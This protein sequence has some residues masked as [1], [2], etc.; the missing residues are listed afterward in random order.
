MAKQNVMLGKPQVQMIIRWFVEYQTEV[1][2]ANDKEW[3]L[4]RYLHEV[5][6]I[7][8]PEWMVSDMKY[9]LETRND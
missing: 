6:E 9:D 4:V 7:E 2:G 1:G 5:L 3:E 8:M